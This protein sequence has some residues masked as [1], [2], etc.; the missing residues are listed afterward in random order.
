V[1]KVRKVRVSTL[2]RGGCVLGG[3]GAEGSATTR[4]Q[5]D[6][7]ATITHSGSVHTLVQYTPGEAD[8]PAQPHLGHCHTL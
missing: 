7:T 6:T 3:G 4:R 2:V 8:R 5:Q 1:E